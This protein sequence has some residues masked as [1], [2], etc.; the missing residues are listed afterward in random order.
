MKIENWKK[1][2]LILSKR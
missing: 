1:N 2:I